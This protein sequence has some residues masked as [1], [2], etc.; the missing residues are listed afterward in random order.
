MNTVKAYK[1]TCTHSLLLKLASAPAAHL[2]R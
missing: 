2:L 1:L